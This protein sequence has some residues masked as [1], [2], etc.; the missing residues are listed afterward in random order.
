MRVYAVTDYLDTEIC[1]LA[2]VDIK[3][4]IYRF[5]SYPIE[6]EKD[7]G[8]VVFYRGLLSDPDF[9]QELQEIGQIKLSSNSIS[10]ST[11]NSQ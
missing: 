6:I 4:T 1:F 10:F 5:S 9:Q 8:Q 11:E 2:E 7:N 3:G